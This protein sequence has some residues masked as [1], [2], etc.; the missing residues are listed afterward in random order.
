MRATTL[1]G[2]LIAASVFVS[3][4]APDA[5]AC[6][7]CFHPP[8]PPMETGSVVTDHQMIFVASPQQT[9]LYDMIKYTGAPSS[10]AW[11]LPIRGTV[12]VGL[13]SDTV[14]A[15]LD[16]LTAPVINPPPYPSCPVPA[17][18]VDCFAAGVSGSSGAGSSGGSS[19]VNVLS[20]AT[21]G[22]Y[23]TVQLQST[24]PMAL[25]TW[26]T[27]NGYSIPADIQPIIAAYVNEGFDF[28][29]LRLAPGQGIQA[30]RPVSVT[31]A[32]AGA[33]LPLRMVAAGTGATVGITLWV[34]S[35]G[36]L[37]AQNFQNFTIAPAELV[38]DW[39]LESSNYTTL[40]QQKETALA[41]AAWQTETSLE[42]SP[43]QIESLVIG[44]GVSVSSSGLS[45][46]GINPTTEGYTDSDGGGEGGT[47]AAEQRT[48]DLAT[49]FPGGG[50]SVRI[51]RMRAD[52]ARAALATDLVLQASADQSI[53]STQY[54]VTQAVNVPMCPNPP[55]CPC[56]GFGGTSSGNAPGYGSSGPSSGGSSGSTSGKEAS[57]CSAASEDSTGG[58]LQLALAG[59]A[60]MLVGSRLRKRR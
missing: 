27:N 34:V 21:V 12:T 19:G 15:A 59:I 26:L 53:I 45:S 51:T 10:F 24:N 17:N 20:Q 39:S 22:P 41:N 50:Q 25:S 57:G 54:Q 4:A 33:T 37:Q 2:A 28:L 48:Q 9:T 44:S 14:F 58:G 36:R 43:Y 55:V 56:G 11:V 8:L 60:A 16:Q 30:M 1:L 46:G 13:S 6:G 42:A 7:G 47:T 49:L 32:G 40:Q 31:S 29:A 18:C 5:R 23:D 38:W 3:A 52:L 35:G